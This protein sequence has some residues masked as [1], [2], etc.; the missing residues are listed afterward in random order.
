MQDRDDSPPN[1]RQRTELDDSPL[2]YKHNTFSFDDG[3]IVLVAENTYFCVHKSLIALNSAVLRDM[4]SMP[5]PFPLV[6]KGE[7][8]EDCPVVR[9]SGDKAAEIAEFLGLVYNGFQRH[10]TLFLFLN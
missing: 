6:D 3:N 4:L 5:Q 2:L 8:I 1:K 7:M 10:I 9:L